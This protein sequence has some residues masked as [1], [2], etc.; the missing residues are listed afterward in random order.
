M[1]EMEMRDSLVKEAL[2]WELTPYVPK[3]CC[4]HF[5]VDCINF[6]Y[7]VYENATHIKL[8][9][10]PYYSTQWH[11]HQRDEL[12]VRTLSEF[13]CLEKSLAYVLPG[14]ILI[15]QIG[16]VGS[17]TGIFLPNNEFMH[18]SCPFPHKVVRRPYTRGWR[19]RYAKRAFAFP[20]V[21]LA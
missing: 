7:G 4:K 21:Q 13:G 20:G 3:Q 17:H 11:L 10:M 15:F 16:K 12:L 9:P 1:N 19:D 5:G 2:E 18:A 6:I 8:P 14:D